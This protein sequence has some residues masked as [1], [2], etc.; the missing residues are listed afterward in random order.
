VHG[1]RKKYEYEILGMNSRLDALQAA[2]LRVKLRHL[3]RWTAAR[4]RNAD[5]YRELFRE[6]RLEALIKSPVVPPGSTHVYNQFTIRVRERDELR[7]HL[8]KR[9]IPTEV[10]YPKPLHLQPAFSFLEHQAGEFLEA[11]SASL[12]VIALPIY[13]ELTEA[14]QRAVVAAIADFGCE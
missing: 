12:E 11:E 3:D 10:Y 5:R 2:I 7:G 8:Q 14:H 1:A 9:G 6:F 13:P 4:R